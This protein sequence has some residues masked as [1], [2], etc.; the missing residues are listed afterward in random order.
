MVRPGERV[1]DQ[2]FKVGKPALQLG[3]FLLQPLDPAFCFLLSIFYFF[4]EPLD[5]RQRHA[6]GIDGRD[7]L[8]VVAS[9]AEGSV[10]ILRHRTDVADGRVFLATN[11]IPGKTARSMASPP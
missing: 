3:V 5:R 7:V 8:V 4:V 11:W 6:V 9:S 10:E 1:S 2:G